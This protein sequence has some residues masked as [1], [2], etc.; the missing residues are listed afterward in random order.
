[1]TVRILLADD[2]VITRKVVELAFPRP[3]YEVSSIAETAA[4]ADRVSEADPDII[5][6]ATGMP[7]GTGYDLCATIRGNPR[8]A[9]VP[10]VLV[11]GSFEP[12]D[13]ARARAAG[14]GGHLRKPFQT[15]ELVA[16]V[17]RLLA[18]SPRPGSQHPPAAAAVRM[19]PPAAER[20]GQPAPRS[21]SAPLA[22]TPPA[23][24]PPAR[25]DEPA[26]AAV[27]EAVA[28]ETVAALAEK[29]VREVAWE[30]IP[31]LAEAIIRRRI[32][33]LEEQLEKRE[34]R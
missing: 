27:A 23:A 19:A 30:V 21:A 10:L 14:S 32:R 18:A 11:A 33:E 29:V 13:E 7:Q 31:D 15:K 28:R 4:S 1:M 25:N 22:G 12:F 9:W 24:A 26:R 16:L 34:E 20:A 17:E 6:I 8:T 5:L 3:R 2:S